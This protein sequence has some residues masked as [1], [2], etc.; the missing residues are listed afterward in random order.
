MIDT[1]TA[2]DDAV[3]LLLALAADVEIEAITTVG[4]NVDVVQ[5]TQNALYTCELMGSRVPVHMGCSKPLL[6]ELETAQHVHG[7][8]G[9]GDIGLP[10]HGREPAPGHA[11]DALISAIRRSPGELT[12]VTLG[13]L[14][15]IAVAL[16]VDPSIARMVRRC[17][18]MGATGDGLGNITP[19]AEYNIY[20]DPHAARLVFESGLPIEVVGWDISRRFATY[21]PHDVQQ[22]RAVGT[23]LAHFAVDIQRVLQEFSLD[24]GLEGF[25]LPDPAAMAVALDPGIVT[26][27]EDVRIDIMVDEG[28]TRGQSIVSRPIDGRR[29]NAG[30]VRALDAQRL[31]SMIRDAVRSTNS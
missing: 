27:A 28:L 2:S 15:N 8:D 30:I 11:V 4:G 25:D 19:V 23:P 17:V 3:A 14:T 29:P 16:A 5:A 18:V 6:F 9:M 10:L 31:R 21:S 22:L 20:V 26:E 1:D 13:P 12:L 7:A 24:L